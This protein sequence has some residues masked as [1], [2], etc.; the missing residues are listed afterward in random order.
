MAILANIFYSYE[1]TY[2]NTSRPSSSQTKGT[3]GFPTHNL[4]FPDLQLDQ[5]QT[6]ESWRFTDHLCLPPRISLGSPDAGSSDIWGEMSRD[7]TKY[8]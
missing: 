7:C 5:L 1:A 2:T 8:R 3:F 6:S 4:T